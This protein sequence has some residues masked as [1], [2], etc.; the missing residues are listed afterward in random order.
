M[1]LKLYS[2]LLFACFLSC[3]AIPLIQG[4]SLAKHG[5]PLRG[6][7]FEPEEKY[8]LPQNSTTAAAVTTHKLCIAAS[9]GELLRELMRMISS[10]LTRISSEV[11]ATSNLSWKAFVEE[12]KILTTFLTN[13]ISKCCQRIYMQVIAWMK[14]F[15]GCIL[16]LIIFMW[17]F[18]IWGIICLSIFLLRQYTLQILSL[19]CLYICSMLLVRTVSKIFGGWPVTAISALGTM[20][21]NL[22]KVLLFRKSSPAYEIPTPGYKSIEIPQKPPRDCVL[23]VQ[24]N[25]AL[26]SPAGYASCVRLLNG[27]NALLTAKHVSNQEGDL[28]IASTRTNNR[29]KFSLFNTILTTKNSDVGLYQ[30]PPGWESIL[31]CKAADITPV[32]GLTCCE[33][34]IF[35]YDGH[36]LRANASL[37]GTEGT[38]VSVLS[39]TEAGY[40]GTPYF[41]G[42]SILGV[43]VGGNT[44]QTNNLMAPIPSIPGLTKHKYVF[45]SPQLKGRLFTEEEV[46]ELEYEIE[47]AY[48]KAIDLVHFKSRTGKNWADYED[49]VLFEAPKFQ[50]NDARGSVRENKTD[51]PT[52]THSPAATS[53]SGTL[54]KVVEALVAKINVSAIERMVVQKISESALKR[55]TNNNRRRRP[56]HKTSEPT[57]TPS[58]DGKYVA[59]AR[60]SQASKPV[61]PSPNTTSQNKRTNQNG[62]GYLQRETLRWQKKS[63]ASGGPSSVPKP[64]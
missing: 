42:K 11:C 62:G 6:T 38:F 43:H 29:I 10:D 55:P 24:H 60:R 27:S 3:F 21:S 52:P 26:N 33:A 61:D 51:L 28:L 36:W 58:T 1:M 45:E 64:N 48:Q 20:I 49:D 7:R 14:I 16:T 13:E 39:N 50:G 25:D 54:D 19:G 34:S 9:Y 40:S 18:L 4:D 12:Q 17:S 15:I 46:K 22:F 31:G 41:N 8:L 59:P 35:R 2:V 53:H 44:A 5:L 56:K 23:L 32:D 30:G 47:E 37:V 63:A 57:S